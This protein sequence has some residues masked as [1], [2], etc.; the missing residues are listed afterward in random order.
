METNLER[1]ERQ[2]VNIQIELQKLLVI[3]E[4]VG[5]SPAA[6]GDKELVD[7]IRHHREVLL[8]ASRGINE[9]IEKMCR[10]A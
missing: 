1:V 8:G 4:H 9:K 10:A 3:V 5:R 7:T 2:L 6:T